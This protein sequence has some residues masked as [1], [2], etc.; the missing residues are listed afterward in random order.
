ME[1]NYKFEL[2]TSKDFDRNN[3]GR[4][5]DAGGKT[6]T[7]TKIDD[8]HIRSVGAGHDRVLEFDEVFPFVNIYDKQGNLVN[9]MDD[10][11]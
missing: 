3:I 4:V 10:Y 5:E 7:L 1:S 2:K 11:D 8:S 6:Y 9:N